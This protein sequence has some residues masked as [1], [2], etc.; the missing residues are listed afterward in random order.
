MELSKT[1]SWFYILSAFMALFIM[2]LGCWWLFLVFKLARQLESANLPSVHGNLITMVQWEGF[3]F[4]AL[5]IS[6]LVAVVYFFFQ[7]HKKT[8]SLHGFFAS[9]THELKTPLTSIKLQ[10]EVIDDLATNLEL[11]EVQK[12]KIKKY[13]N[14]LVQDS[15]RLEIE[16][17]KHLQLSRLERAGNLNLVSVDIDNFIKKEAKIYSDKFELELISPESYY[18]QAEDFALKTIFRNLFENSI[19]HHKELKK[20]QISISKNDGYILVEYNDFGTEFKED[21]NELGKL[22]VKFNSPKGSGIGLYL[23]KQLTLKM[24]GRFVI[25]NDNGLKFKLYFN[26]ENSDE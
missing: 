11:N 13:T 9:L 8:K 15:S 3:T 23:I 20:I 24:K 16:L 26:E 2:V 19:R 22:F 21:I 1:K 14:R 12:D 10:A 17:D 5:V 18:V 7:D 25:T 6:L 4:F